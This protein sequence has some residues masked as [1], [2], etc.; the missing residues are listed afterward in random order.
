MGSEWEWKTWGDL[1]LLEYGK[2]LRDYQESDGPFRVF[3]TNGPIGWH[4][5]PLCPFPS[6]II[7]RKGAYRGIHFSPDPFYV[8][9]TAFYLNPKVKFNIKWAYYELLTHD[10]NGMDSGSAIP[11]T[12]RDSFYS[13]PVIVPPE[14]EQ[15]AIAHILG[16]L[17]DKIELNRRMNE[18]L[19]AMARAI[20]KSWFVDF[21]PVRAKAEGRNTGLPNEISDLFPNSF[22]DSELGEIP[23]GWEI[24]AI[25][26]IGIQSRTGVKPEEIKSSENYIALEHMP[27]RSIS[28]W[29]WANSKNITSG[30]FRFKKSNILFGK[31]RP[32]FHKVGVP[33]IDG[34]C[35]TD[36]VVVVPNEEQ[37]Y[38][39]LLGHLSS[40]AFVSYTNSAST[41][42]KMPRTNWKDMS[43][44]LIAIPDREVSRLFTQYLKHIVQ[45][46]HSNIYESNTLASL[47]DTL[48]PKL[49]SGEIRIPEA[50]KPVEAAV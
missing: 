28:L 35:S 1:A 22:E 19:E 30:K 31:L 26:D 25:G 50:E 29:N 36:I 47:R 44:F 4:D 46:L 13:L 14:D 15:N 32:Y 37:Y 8:I 6:V 23:K 45:K 7:G 21:D 40:D 43:C 24:G 5:E 16:S 9:D 20:F 49:I 11:S 38:G 34:V 17:D 41:G 33:A 18:T 48:L 39:L 2:G 42:T 3:G 12:S 27:K 10:I